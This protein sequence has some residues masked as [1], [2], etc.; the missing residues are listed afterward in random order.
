[1]GKVR[2]AAHLRGWHAY[3]PRKRGY[4]DLSFFVEPEAIA[5]Y[6]AASRI[7][8]LV[9]FGQYATTAATAQ[10]FSTLAATGDMARLRALAQHATW[11]NVVVST[12]AAI[13]VFWAAPSLLSLFGAGFES[14]ATVL[15]I[16]VA[17]LILQAAAGPGEDILNMLGHQRACAA[18]FVVSLALNVALNLALIPYFGLIGAALATTISVGARSFALSWVVKSRLGMNIVSRSH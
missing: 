3:H 2:V 10:R 13:V 1:M 12:A 11:F 7:L 14:G 15:T 5:I 8:Q 16:L 6:Y 18:T 9:A 17:G 4:L